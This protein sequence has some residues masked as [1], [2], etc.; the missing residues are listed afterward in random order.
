[1][2][3]FLRRRVTKKVAVAPPSNGAPNGN[4]TAEEYDAEVDAQEAR[5][6]AAMARIHAACD[7]A[8]SGV[9]TRRASGGRVVVKP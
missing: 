9:R 5:A 7:A 1:M 6:T 8:M 4:T 3:K 2:I